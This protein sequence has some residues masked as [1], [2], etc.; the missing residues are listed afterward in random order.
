MNNTEIMKMFVTKISLQLFSRRLSTSKLWNNRIT[1]YHGEVYEK[2]TVVY[3]CVSSC[4]CINYTLP[5]YWDSIG[6][7]ANCAAAEGS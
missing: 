4:Y 6:N 3:Q 7:V 2:F 1:L 5:H